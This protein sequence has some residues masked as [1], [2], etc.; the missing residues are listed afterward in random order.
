MDIITILVNENTQGEKKAQS[1]EESK[2]S[3]LASI[4]NFFG[5]ETRA[6]QSNNTNLDPANL[7]NASTHSKF[8]GDTQMK[9][10]GNL[11][12]KVSAVIME[13]FPNG[14][15]R[16]EGTKI[17]SIDSEEEIVVITGLVRSRDIDSLNQVDSSRIADMRIDLYG[18]GLMAEHTRPGW[19]ARAFQYIWPF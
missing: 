15:M 10:S 19:G 13:V 5:L 3:L 6:W 14:L 4:A 11:Q 16:I 17:V 8:E 1:D 18:Q 12:A 2:F 7:I 9:R